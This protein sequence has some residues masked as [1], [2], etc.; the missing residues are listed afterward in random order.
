MMA[1]PIDKTRIEPPHVP[2]TA[3]AAAAGAARP[4]GRRVLARAA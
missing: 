1:E 4:G 3:A 2:E